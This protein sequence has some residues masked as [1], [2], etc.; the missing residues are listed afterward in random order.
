MKVSAEKV[1]EEGLNTGCFV[2]DLN[3]MECRKGCDICPLDEIASKLTNSFSS[4]KDGPGKF[5]IRWVEY[6]LT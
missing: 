2:Y 6:M 5:L 4:I 3:S 1:R